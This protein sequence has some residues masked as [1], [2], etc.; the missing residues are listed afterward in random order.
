M[1]NKNPL[2]GLL[3]FFDFMLGQSIYCQNDHLYFGQASGGGQCLQF[4]GGNGWQS[5]VFL[6]CVCHLLHRKQFS[7]VVSPIG[8]PD[9]VVPHANYCN[10][11]AV[12]VAC[13]CSCGHFVLRSFH[14]LTINALYSVLLYMSSELIINF[15]NPHLLGGA[16]MTTRKRAQKF[17]T[18]K[19]PSQP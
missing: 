3:W 5:K 8:C 11:L 10:N 12:L 16:L 13:F 7:D 14:Y 17:K 1:T 15:T 19:S 6:L 2:T 4:I 9:Y 18:D